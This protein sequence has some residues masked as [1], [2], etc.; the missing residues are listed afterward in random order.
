MNPLLLLFA[1]VVLHIQ[2]CVRAE[3]VESVVVLNS[4]NYAQTKTG[5]W[6]IDF[7]A[8]WCGH[9]KKLAPVM[10]TLGDRLEKDKVAVKLG[11]I[12]CTVDSTLCP[13]IS[14]YPTLKLFKGG[15][16]IREY[17]GA[18]VEQ[19]LY[20]FCIKAAGPAVQLITR[21]VYNTIE[22][23]RAKSGVTFLQVGQGRREELFKSVAETNMESTFI[24]IT[25]DAHSIVVARDKYGLQPYDICVL[26]DVNGNRPKVW[27]GQGEGQLNAWIQAN[28]F[29]IFP[30][31]TIDNYHSLLESGRPLVVAFVDETEP[32]QKLVS[33]LRRAAVVDFD[34]DHRYSMSFMRVESR[35]EKQYMQE[36][37]V[38]SLPSLLALELKNELVY[39][40]P[41]ADYSDKGVR[42]FFEEYEG[43]RLY[44]RGMGGVPGFLRR[45]V[46]YVA[47]GGVALIGLFVLALYYTL[48]DDTLP[49][50]AP[51]N[52]KKD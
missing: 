12:D 26:N 11:K 16:E 27:Q 44:S 43:G 6:L 52:K 40:Y 33:S 45:N 47:A 9:C 48:D 41:D 19:K 35:A 7:Y 1:G 37:G 28:R 15:R 18:R 31:L 46:W 13:G 17:K 3:T 30:P 20:D 24:M 2:L 5:S 34:G 29:P 50:A 39:P 22:S 14:G 51:P 23:I 36:L 4:T 25:E 38:S 8:P 32:S 21:D 42:K 10:E 49:A